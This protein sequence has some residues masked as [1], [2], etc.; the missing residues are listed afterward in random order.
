MSVA[1][2]R[3]TPVNDTSERSAYER[4][5]PGPMR[6]PLIAFHPLGSIGVPTTEP[7]LTPLRLAPTKLV[8]DRSRPAKLKFERF[9][10]AKFAPGP[11]K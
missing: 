8:E 7:D 2:I 4:F 9:A 3:L 6:Y 11:I 1:P 10:F 5:A